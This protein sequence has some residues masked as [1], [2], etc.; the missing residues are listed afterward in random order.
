MDARG[1]PEPFAAARELAA[2]KRR[3]IRAWSAVRIEHVE[4][5]DGEQ[6]P[7]GSLV[8]RASVA[9]GG[10]S[11]ADVC[12]EVAYGRVGDDDEIISPATSALV[13]ESAPDDGV[14]R[15]RGQGGAGPPGAVRLHGPGGARAIRCWPQPRNS[16]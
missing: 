1:R 5:E 10:L 8:V 7:G 11:P 6:G 9:L 12:V 4:G 13:L 2:W 15:V 14:A 16:G 3:V